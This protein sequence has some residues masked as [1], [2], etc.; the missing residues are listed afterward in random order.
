MRLL[1][2]SL[3]AASAHAL[4]WTQISQNCNCHSARLEEYATGYS[5]AEL[6]GAKCQANAHCRS[7]GVWT[8]TSR[9]AGFCA[10]FD[11]V[12]TTTCQHPTNMA[13]NQFNHVYN[14]AAVDSPP[15][16]SSSTCYKK[17]PSRIGC[18][19]S[20]RNLGFIGRPKHFISSYN[21]KCV[22]ATTA[23]Y[24]KGVQACDK[25]NSGTPGKCVGFAMHRRWGVQ[26]YDSRTI[27]KDLCQAEDGLAFNRDWTFY[28]VETC[29]ASV[30]V[31]PSGV[32]LTNANPMDSVAIRLSDP[33]SNPVAVVLN[34]G[35]SGV[36][37]V[38]KCVL[39]FNKDNWDTAQT[40]RVAL[41][42][43]PSIVTQE[44]IVIE[45][46]GVTAGTATGYENTPSKVIRTSRDEVNGPPA[47]CSSAGDPHYTS[48]DRKDRKS[49]V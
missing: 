34:S 15:L 16:D 41:V 39:V 26:M 30:L 23:C 24:N 27:N 12:C 1:I 43:T 31:E 18:H 42:Q 8:S 28:M 47:V 32:A 25:I 45:V 11:R 46:K 37:G 22:G 33:P 20:R 5:S 29:H 17:H 6:C 36:F 10:L 49:V 7:F 21:S 38:S 35:A 4:A 9:A 44:D 14:M 2:L 40:V 19:H 48:F 3:L 13:N